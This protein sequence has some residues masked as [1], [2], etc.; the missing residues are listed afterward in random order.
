MVDGLLRAPLRELLCT[1]STFT[2]ERSFDGGIIVLDMPTKL[3]GEAGR[4]AQVAI[5]TSW[6]QA[7]ERR[8]ID[9]TSLPVCL[10]QDEAQQFVTPLDKTFAETGRDKLAAT[11]SLTQSLSGFYSAMQSPD[12]RAMCDAYIACLNTKIFHFNEDPATCEFAERLFGKEERYRSSGSLSV[13]GRRNGQ[14]HEGPSVRR[15]IDFRREDRPR[16]PGASLHS[17][18]RG[19]EENELKVDSIISLAGELIRHTFVQG[20]RRG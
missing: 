18:R 7:V 1:D 13:E 15:H 14:Q 4:Q 5:K 19:G 20:E 12:P 8:L 16:V 11:V 3:F 6:M 2:P 17:L 10:W 9:D